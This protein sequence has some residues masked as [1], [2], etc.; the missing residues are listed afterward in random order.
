LGKTKEIKK[1]SNKQKYDDLVNQ[2]ET[3]LQQ[4]ERQGIDL[5]DSRT[6]EGKKDALMK[7][8]LELDRIDNGINSLR[9]KAFPENQ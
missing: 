9:N 5:N 7:I 1:Y 8:D 4:A 3:I 2:M 6:F